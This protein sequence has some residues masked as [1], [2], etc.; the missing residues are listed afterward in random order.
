[1]VVDLLAKFAS[2]LATSPYSAYHVIRKLDPVHWSPSWQ[3]WFVTR[4]EDVSNL[5]KDPALSVARVSGFSSRLIASPQEIAQA[6]P[7]LE[8]IES[9]LSRFLLFTDL[10]AHSR[11]RALIIKAFTP[12]SIELMKDRVEARVESL[13]SGWSEGQEL[14]L[15][16]ALAVPLPVMTIADFLGSRPDDYLGLAGWSHTLA[17]FLGTDSLTPHLVAD[18]LAS[19][20]G[21]ESYFQ[22]LLGQRRL[23]P[24]EDLLSRLLA[25]QHEGTQLRDDEILAMGI[26]LFAAG[27]DTTTNLIGNGLLAVLQHPAERRLMQSSQEALDRGLEEILRYD[28]PSLIATR[29]V[30]RPFELA[31]KQFQEG[32]GINLCMGAANR[33]PAVFVQPDRFWID[34]PVCSHIAFGKG[35]HFCVGS[36]LARLEARSVLSQFL[37]RWPNS[38]LLGAPERIPTLA[39]R[40]L[41]HLK[42]R[43]AA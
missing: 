7:L 13:M 25:V 40:R 37:T 2:Q 9:W 35:M 15:L 32:D 23:Q 36:Y 30:A 21:M 1:M 24:Q 20:E 14:D 34:R 4:H 18:T 43:L 42:V 8:R 17:S 22:D 41:R 33:D 31:G 12:R 29:W 6:R 38:Q 28:S 10:P 5:M 3:S 27:H 11:L 39:F 19:F 16:A 26:L